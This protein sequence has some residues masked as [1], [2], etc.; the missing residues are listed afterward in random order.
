MYTL[1]VNVYP[2]RDQS[3]NHRAMCVDVSMAVFARRESTSPGLRA[4][5]YSR[6]S[7]WRRVL[8]A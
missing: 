2:A 1:L 3:R 7:H 5:P 8:T 6:R 4:W